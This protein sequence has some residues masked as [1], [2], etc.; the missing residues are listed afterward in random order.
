M[1]LRAHARSNASSPAQAPVGVEPFF[2]RN[3]SA[4]SGLSAILTLGLKGYSRRS[5][6]LDEAVSSASMKLPEA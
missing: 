3:S 5:A 4:R 1:H 6:L 2:H